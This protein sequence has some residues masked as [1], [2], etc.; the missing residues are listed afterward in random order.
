MFHCDPTKTE[1]VRYTEA[2]DIRTETQECWGEKFSEHLIR[3]HY[4]LGMYGDAEGQAATL[5][6]EATSLLSPMWA[7]IVTNNAQMFGSPTG[8]EIVA[9]I[10][11]QGKWGETKLRLRGDF[12][13]QEAIIAYR[14]EPS[15]NDDNV[16]NAFF[17]EFPR[18]PK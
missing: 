3:I 7:R 12:V 8:L 9:K 10:E 5:R 17:N 15:K 13:G 2:G 6:G 14:A 11:K 4:P 16:A 1:N 18:S